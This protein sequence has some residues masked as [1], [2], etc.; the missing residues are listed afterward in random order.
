MN[1]DISYSL[2]GNARLFVKENGQ[3]IKDT[4]YIKNLILNSGMDQIVFRPFAE[5]ATCCVIG[6]GSAETRK[7]S[8][9]DIINYTS[10]NG[11][12]SNN[13]NSLVYRSASIVTFLNTH[14][15]ASAVTN[16]D[17]NNVIK[18]DNDGEYVISSVSSPLTCSVI[19]IN[20]SNPTGTTFNNNYTIYFTNQTTMSGELYRIGGTND[21]S[22]TPDSPSGYYGVCSSLLQSAGVKHTRTYYLNPIISALSTTVREIGFGWSPVLNSPTLFSRIR[23]TEG[24]SGSAVTLNSGQELIVLY[25]LNIGISPV[26][27]IS[28]STPLLTTVS[29]S[30]QCESYGL[31][32]VTSTGRTSYFDDSYHGN[33]P[34][35]YNNYNI[36]GLP[37]SSY[38]GLYIYTSSDSSSFSSWGTNVNRTSNY[39]TKSIYYISP[40]TS[41]QYS[42]TKVATFNDIESIN[43]D[44]RS[45]GIGV[46]D[47]KNLIS[48]LF[49][50]SQNKQN[51]YLL[52]ISQSFN[53]TR[54]LS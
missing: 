41:S 33:E 15:T 42:V 10:G 35:Y 22:L 49:N 45:F 3:I 46:N 39:V 19:N 17:I 25:E 21:N 31:S 1:K 27:P 7:T 28:S 13:Y 51:G 38:G 16:S 2:Y 9:P 11:Y 32:K 44:F 14:P 29:G 40:Y 43:S 47:S 52:S 4:G 37:T 30:V 34:Y 50:S 12:N 23:L 8:N 5:L 20:G 6:T 48:F 24:P 53:W 54:V 18:I 26:T 36:Y